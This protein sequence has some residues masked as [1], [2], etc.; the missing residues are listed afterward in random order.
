[1]GG[2]WVLAAAMIAGCGIVQDG[3]DFEQGLDTDVSDV[4]TTVVD[5]ETKPDTDTEPDTAL[6][7]DTDTPPAPGLCEP[8]LPP[9]AATRELQPGEDLQQAIDDASPGDTLLLGD[10]TWSLPGGVWIRTPG[11]TIRS[12]SGV[13]GAVVLDGQRSGSV[14]NIYA[15]DVTIASLTTANA[16]WHGVHVVGG[17]KADTTGTLLYDLHV[18]DPGQQG[19]KINQ[20]AG[21]TTFPDDGEIACSLIELTD[22][23]RPYVSG[24]YTGGID[25]HAA[26]GWVVRDNEITGFWCDSGLSE[27]GVHFWRSSRDTVVER[28]RIWDNAAGALRLGLGHG[29]GYRPGAG[30]RGTGAAQQRVLRPT[31]VLV[32]RMA[33]RSD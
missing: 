12:S 29:R 30:L 3:K 14:V 32:H 16:Q 18:L 17:D 10:G 6:P 5:T 26:R 28:N 19:I 8:L 22:V 9:P 7:G 2:P 11:L 21:Y 25:A 27:H 23:G 33:L 4:D 15:S 24:C 13:R 31:T 20:N 1:M